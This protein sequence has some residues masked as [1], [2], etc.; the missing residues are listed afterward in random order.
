MLPSRSRWGRRPW[1]HALEPRSE[2]A[3]YARGLVLV[4]I[5][6]AVWAVLR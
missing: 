4:G 6:A 2:W 3:D 5:A 1:W